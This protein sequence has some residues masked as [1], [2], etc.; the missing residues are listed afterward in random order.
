MS[1]PTNYLVLNPNTGLYQD[2]ADLFLPRQASD[3]SGN[4]TGFKYVDANGNQTDINTLFYPWSTGLTQIPFNT[5]MVPLKGQDLK[6]IFAASS[7]APFISVTGKYTYSYDAT[8]KYY[9]L[10]FANY[11]STN[12]EG[13]PSNIGNS[14]STA[15]LTFIAAVSGVTFT[16]VAGGG[17]GGGGNKNYQSG[18]GGAGGDWGQLIVSGTV[19]QNTIYNI[20]VGGGGTAGN[21]STGGQGGSSSV[22]SNNI[23]LLSKT[24]GNGGQTRISGYTP[25]PGGVGVGNGESGGFGAVGG[26]TSPTNGVSQTIKIA[27]YVGGTACYYGGGGAGGSI[28]AQA[29]AG[30]GYITAAGGLGGGAGTYA[31]SGLLYTGVNGITYPASTTTTINGLAATGGGGAGGNAQANFPTVV[32]PTSGGQGA[33]GIVICCF[34]VAS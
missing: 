8:N 20:T 22:L 33:S 24:G 1:T 32:G 16:V 25:I 34:Q 18:G 4:T 6:Y 19:A 26:A 28:G 21:F 12:P 29:D 17:G 9:T 27:G 2:L 5:N 3:P 14:S 15:T 30:G 10:A 23:T 31:N 13:D 11:L 7:V